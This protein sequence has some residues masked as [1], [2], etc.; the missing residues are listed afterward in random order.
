MTNHELNFRFSIII[1]LEFHRGQ[2]EACLHRWAY[3]QT[4]PR[5]QY[6]VIAAGCRSSFDEETLASFE[7]N[8]DTNDRLLLYDQPHDI[9]LNALA[10][11]DA[12]EEI[13][14]FT[15]SHCLPERNALT[16]TNQMLHTHPEWSGFSGSTSRVV[17]NRLSVAEADMYEAD[18]RFGMEKHPWL[19]LLD[20]YFVV[21]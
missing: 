14:I 19:K 13:L 15:E 1:P 18:I 10:A 3:E 9:A 21:W 16:L 7:S 12:R 2:V 4:Y 8:L 20:Q 11:R 5:N 17:H 6:E